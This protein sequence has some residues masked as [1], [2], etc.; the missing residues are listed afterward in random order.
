VSSR[1]ARRAGATPR[2]EVSRRRF[3]GT[4]GALAATTAVAPAMLGG[5]V[6]GA[7]TPRRVSSGA[8]AFH[9]PH[10]AGIATPAQDRLLFAT[11]DL[12][13]D[14]S[15]AGL[16]ALLHTWTRAS[17]RMTAGEP[18]GDDN[19]T[20]LAP[21]DDT[22]EAFGLPPSNLTITFGFGPSLFTTTGDRF[23]IAAARPTALADLPAFPR[24]ELEPARSGGDLAVQACADDP[25]VCFHAVRNLTRMARGTAVLRWS[26]LGFGRTSS[27]SAAQ[28]TPR[29]LMGFKDGTNNLTK[30]DGTLLDGQVWVAR[31]DDPAW[32]RGGTYLVARRIRILIEV[33]DRSSLDDQQQTIGRSK[34]AGAPLGAERE[35]DAVDLRARRGGKL[36]IPPDAHIRLAAPATNGGAHLLRRGYSFTDGIDPVTNQLDAGL[37]FLAY[38]RDPRRQFVPVQTRLAENDALNEYIRHTGSALFAV[39]PGVGAGGF[40]G[41]TLLT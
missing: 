38:Q 3:L 41:E 27:T 17:E 4:A 36:V 10:Q 30:Q 21:P 32:M 26:Q 7:A 31:R 24:D 28:Q 35:H 22:G 23:G 29:N 34:L 14:A 5:S 19:A 33:W 8:V 39:P 15:R 40:V 20:L 6:A 1:G 2:R 18:V 16:V 37:F 12:E 13:P 25:Q 9:G 11:F